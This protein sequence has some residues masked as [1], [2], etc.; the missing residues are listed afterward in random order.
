MIYHADANGISHQLHGCDL[1]KHLD[2]LSTTKIVEGRFPILE[3]FRC[4]SLAVCLDVD[5][6]T[7][8]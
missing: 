8:A 1:Q 7:R 6:H 2:H 5:H 4:D 3:A